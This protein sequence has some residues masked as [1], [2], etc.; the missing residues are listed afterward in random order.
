LSL[1]QSRK[2]GKKEMWLTGH[3]ASN[4]QGGLHAP[5]M[6]REYPSSAL[7]PD[8]MLHFQK[9][10]LKYDTVHLQK[11]SSSL[12]IIQGFTTI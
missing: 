6:G 2:K 1:N 3:Q 7:L 12:L 8:C 11:I 4:H 9:E 5:P 10:I